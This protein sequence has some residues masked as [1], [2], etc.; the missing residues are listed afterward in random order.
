M[1]TKKQAI[2]FFEKR[3]PKALREKGIV[4]IEGYSSPDGEEQQFIFNGVYLIRYIVPEAMNCLMKKQNYAQTLRGIK[5]SKK[6]MVKYG[7]YLKSKGWK[8]DTANI[9]KEI[10]EFIEKMFK[11]YGFKGSFH[12]SQLNE[13]DRIHLQGLYKECEE[14]KQ[15][16]N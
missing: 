2:D 3:S 5:C 9:I 6:E 10:D 14:S 8:T 12:I 7:E 16:L 1:L 13:E 11:K 4:S 15:R